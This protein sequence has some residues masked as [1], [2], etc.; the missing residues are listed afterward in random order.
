VNMTQSPELFMNTA[1]YADHGIIGI[2]EPVFDGGVSGAVK[3]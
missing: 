3:G 1:G 2:D